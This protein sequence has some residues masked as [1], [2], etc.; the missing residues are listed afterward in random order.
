MS[1]AAQI[2]RSGVVMGGGLLL[3]LVSLAA[4]AQGWGPD[5]KPLANPFRKPSPQDETPWRD[6]LDRAFAGSKPHVSSPWLEREMRDFAELLKPG[7][8]D[9]VVAPVRSEGYSLDR[10][11]R[12]L[13]HAEVSRELAA[14][15]LRVPN[16][17]AVS[18]ALGEGRRR[19]E[20]GELAA[21]ARPLGAAKIVIIGI[22]HDRLGHLAVSL[23]V[24]AVKGVV[25]PAPQPRNLPEF[26][27]AAGE[28][29]SAVSR[30]IVPAVL[31]E[32]ALLGVPPVR[33]KA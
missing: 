22:S 25:P 17:V 20:S 16:P 11:S 3:A 30:V 24:Q 31:E 4:A 15:K 21:F 7:P 9:V 26:T 32:L 8:Y 10:I 33:G 14:R 2:V 1:G 6:S 29:P 13:I 5:G 28:H 23:T 27:L 12:A 18:R 19:V